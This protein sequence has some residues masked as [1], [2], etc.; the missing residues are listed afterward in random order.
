MGLAAEGLI[1]RALGGAL[2]EGPPRPDMAG[3]ARP[4]ESRVEGVRGVGAAEEEEEEE[5]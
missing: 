3:L 4:P 2:A 1:A 5:A